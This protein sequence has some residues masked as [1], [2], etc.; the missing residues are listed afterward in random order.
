MASRNAI[1]VNFRQLLSGQIAEA[2]E[3]IVALGAMSARQRVAQFLLELS[4]RWASRGYSPNEFDLCLTRKEIGSYL[5]L[6]FET[7]SR[8]L[9]SFDAKEWVA[10]DGRHVRIRDHGALRAALLDH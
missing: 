10:V 7:V 6:T 3:R 5:G 1:A 2:G 8:T 9:S 4:E